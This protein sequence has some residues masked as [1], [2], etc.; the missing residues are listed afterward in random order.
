MSETWINH[1]RTHWYDSSGGKP[2]DDRI[3]IG[4]LQRI[5][6]A[7][8]KMAASYDRMREDR[9]TCKRMYQEA[10]AACERLRRSNA[11][12]RGCLRR[13]KKGGTA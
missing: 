2:C 7:T 3:R 11:A 13:M 5:A 12:L 6:D 1:S 4:C 8:E 9:D 10:V